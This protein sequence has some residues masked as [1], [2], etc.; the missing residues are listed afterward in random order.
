MIDKI[1]SQF[2]I[3]NKENPNTNSSPITF[4]DSGASSLTPDTVID[5]ITKYYKDYSV[6][7]HRGLYKLSE[8][9]TNLCEHSRDKVAEFI[10]ANSQEIIFTSGTT[11]GL[12]MLSQMLLPEVK[13]GD[14]IVISIAE[15]HANILPWQKIAKQI[16]NVEIR[17]IKLDNN[18]ELD[19][20]HA[21][22]LIDSNT[23]IV[24]VTGMSNVMGTIPDCKK[25]GQLAHAVN[26]YMIIDA[27]QS[28]SHLKTDV[29]DLDCDFLA[30]G[31]HKMYGPTGVGVLYGKKELLK[32]IDPV[33]VGGDIVS[34]VTE[35][36]ATWVDAPHK[37]ETGTPHIAGIIAMA[38]AVDFIQSIGWE[39]IKKHEEE[40]NEYALTKLKNISGLKI[41]GPSDFVNRGANYAFTIDGLHT[42]DIADILAK[43]NIA[44]RAGSHCAM[45]LSLAL[46]IN[47]TTRASCG[48]YTT[49]QDIDKLVIGLEKAINIFK[50]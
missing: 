8:T 6:N 4:L 33:F 1:K 21:K 12:N 37:F 9:A 16:G 22:T 25:L 41:I 20:D 18:Y 28:I 34:M 44:V 35:Q 47:G 5:A 24:S 2:K 38:N 11:L 30:F 23:K 40:L 46:N 13:P 39:Y 27:A 29:K 15:H 45:P 36:G 10:N 49:K 19:L 48:I 50:K 17:Y 43:Q 26:A 31:G 3:F 32:N 14:N 7:I 42:H